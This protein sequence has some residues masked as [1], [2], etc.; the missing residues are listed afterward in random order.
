MSL[1]LAAFFGSVALLIASQVQRRTQ[2]KH[3]WLNGLIKGL[4]VIVIGLAAA[5]FYQRF[6]T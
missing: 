2:G 1:A 5:Y 3:V 6:V 4:A